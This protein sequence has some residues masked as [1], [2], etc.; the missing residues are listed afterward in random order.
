MP[1]VATLASQRLAAPLSSL[2]ANMRFTLRSVGL[3]LLL[4]Y[5][6]VL[7]LLVRLDPWSRLRPEPLGRHW[8]RTLLRLLNIRVSGSGTR[9]RGGALIVANHISWLDIPLLYAQTGT[10]FVSKSEVQAWPVVGW[11][12]DAAGTFYLRRGHH[13]SRPLLG[14]LVPF[15]R[16]GG[17]AVIFPEG[18]TTTGEEVRA[19]HPRLFAAA[20]ESGCPV[21]PVALRYGPGAHGE[22]LAPFVGDDDLVRHVLRLLRNPGLEA[23]VVFCAPLDAS[24][25]SREQLADAAREAIRTV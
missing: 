25:C 20:I 16:A 3:T 14:R 4:V 9:H 18:T 1:E 11:L 6:M 8:S 22:S 10:R 21:Q 19:F 23:R 13:G 7:A 12:A 5:G 2:Q 24:G 17:S 15:L